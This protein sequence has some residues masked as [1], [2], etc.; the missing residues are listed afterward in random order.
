[1]KFKNLDR[2]HT[3]EAKKRGGGVKRLAKISKEPDAGT[4]LCI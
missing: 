3:D 2:T 4:D 1:M